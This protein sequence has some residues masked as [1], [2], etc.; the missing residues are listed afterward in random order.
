[1]Q[2]RITLPALSAKRRF[3]VQY[4]F[5]IFIMINMLKIYTVFP[6][7]FIHLIIHIYVCMFVCSSHSRI[8][9]SFG[10]VTI[11]G[12]RMKMINARLVWPLSSKGSLACHTYCDPGH[13]SIIIKF[14]SEDTHFYCRAFDSGATT[15]Y[16]NDLAL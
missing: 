10:D 11:I 8:F 12:E 13:S 2:R 4:L 5:M 9:H 14:I 7:D 16:F 3:H 1:M 15:I 6:E